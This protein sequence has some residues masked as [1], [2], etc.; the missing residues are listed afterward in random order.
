MGTNG[1]T[2][3]D[4]TQCPAYCCS[5]YERVQVNK[6]DVTRLARHF[7]V[8]EDVAAYRYTKVVNKERI[9]RRKADPL[10]GKSCMFLNT[11]SRQCTI[12]HARPGT[13]RQFPDTS[14]C[15][16]WDLLKFEKQQQGDP[17][18]L[19]LV[20]ITFKNEIKNRNRTAV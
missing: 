19:P 3:Y 5:I 15:A 8:S 13:C 16:Y 2:Y 6:R 17:E 1:R 20:Q 4:C 18:A 11:T 12:Y 10:M 14:R 9:L 7:G